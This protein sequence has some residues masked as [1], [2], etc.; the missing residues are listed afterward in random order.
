MPDMGS[1]NAVDASAS[2]WAVRLQAEACVTIQ[3]PGTPCRRCAEAC[4]ADAVVVGE[5][6]LEIRGDS[7]TGCG[8]CAAGCPTGA[9]D[10]DG[11]ALAVGQRSIRIECSRVPAAEC[12]QSEAIVPCL[13]GLTARQFRAW[14]T[15]GTDT[16]VLVNRHWCAAC[17]A[18]GTDEPWAATLAQILRELDLLDRHGNHSI[19]VEFRPL[20]KDA[21]LSPPTPRSSTSTTLTRRQLFR[22][23][24]HPVPKSE[25]PRASACKESPSLVSADALDERRRHLARLSDGHLSAGLFPSVSIADTCCDNQICIHACPTGAL[26]SVQDDEFAGTAFDA[27]LCIACGICEESCPTRSITLTA[28]GE[29]VYEGPVALR[30]HARQLCAQC[31]VEFAA[32]DDRS[33]CLACHKDADIVQLGH[34]LMRRRAAACPRDAK[35]REIALRSGAHCDQETCEQEGST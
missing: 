12:S 27:A 34:E 6:T 32:T 26:R 1:G 31:G 17:P 14:L 2:M 7:C 30:C 35:V 28:A 5:R 8:R 10:L 13:G 20:A 4:P 21:A 16:I 29:G 15:S 19:R 23:L 33:I 3:R 25:T 18:G 11:A 22:R 9:L 24:S